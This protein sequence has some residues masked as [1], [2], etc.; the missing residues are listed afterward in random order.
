MA[1]EAVTLCHGVPTMFALLLQDGGFTRQALPRLRT[2][3]IA[4]SPVAPALVRAVR[5]VCDV[6]I[7]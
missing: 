6:E 1:A 5:A 7:A 3:L 2:G 4:G